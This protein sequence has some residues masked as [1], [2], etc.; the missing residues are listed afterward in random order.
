MSGPGFQIYSQCKFR[1][2]AMPYFLIP[3][4]GRKK[5]KKELE[6]GGKKKKKKNIGKEK[7]YP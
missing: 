1:A 5:K 2:K 7:L 4:I 6:G 3:E